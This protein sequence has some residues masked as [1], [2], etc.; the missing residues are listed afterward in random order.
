MLT[1]SNIYKYF[2]YQ[3]LF[4]NYLKKWKLDLI[5]GDSIAQS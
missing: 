2:F 3:K 5:F 1:F 4:N